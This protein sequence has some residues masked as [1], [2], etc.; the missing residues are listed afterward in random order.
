MDQLSV[1]VAARELR[2]SP[3]QLS[4]TLYRGGHDANCPLVLGRRLIPRSYLP[5]L[6]QALNRQVKRNKASQ[7]SEPFPA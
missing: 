3:W 4:N 6:A 7:V 5:T 1:S 2:V